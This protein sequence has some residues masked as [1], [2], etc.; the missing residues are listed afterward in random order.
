M[1]CHYIAPAFVLA[2]LAA[3]AQPA[4]TTFTA[5]V[6]GIERRAALDVVRLQG[7]DYVSA[8]RLVE[9]FG[10]TYQVLPTRMKVD[11]L[12]STAWLQMN[13]Y[14]VNALT[15]FTL[16]HPVRRHDGDVLLAVEDVSVFFAKAFRIQVRGDELAEAPPSVTI[17]PGG[18]TPAPVPPPSAQ[19]A[20]PPLPQPPL[21]R[22]VRVIAIDAGHGGYDS[23][24]EGAGGLAAK[25]LLL[26]LAVRLRD[27]LAA[28]T[29]LTVVLTREQD[30]ALTPAQRTLLAMNREADILVGLEVG[31]FFSATARGA[32]IFCPEP[33]ERTAL[34]ER[35]R[36]FSEQRPPHVADYSKQSGDIASAIAVALESAGTAPLRGVYQVPAR[37]FHRFAR[38][39]LIIE[40]GC[41]TNPS[42]EAL[43][44]T[45]EHREALV[46]AIADGF[47]GY[48]KSKSGGAAAP[49]PLQPVEDVSEPVSQ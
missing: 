28:T 29:G 4:V 6:Q 31:A 25:D 3:T 39:A 45:E 2:V 22:S 7:V 20:V 9:Q 41:L 10:G 8:T 21:E 34:P 27:A 33:Q 5:N 47:A 24:P 26:D 19:P 11:W 30:V 13:D 49:T 16:R 15:I 17:L 46:Q 35:L 37:L 48:L 1:R 18:R 40:V 42:D 32:A 44:A 43:L 36:A 14:R 23:G 38:P 12:N